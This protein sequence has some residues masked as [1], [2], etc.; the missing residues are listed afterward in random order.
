M[1]IDGIPQAELLLANGT[2]VTVDPERRVLT[3][4]SVAV[5][6]GRIVEIGPSE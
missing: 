2:I 3:H 5:A 4:S 1:T 6:N